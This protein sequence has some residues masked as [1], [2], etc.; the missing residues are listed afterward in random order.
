MGI[1]WGGSMKVMGSSIRFY[2]PS[3]RYTELF[4]SELVRL[5]SARLWISQIL[6]KDTA[7]IAFLQIEELYPKNSGILV[8]LNS[9]NDWG[10]IFVYAETDA[11]EA[12]FMMQISD[13][14]RS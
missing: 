14:E 8:F 12:A 3:E 2:R 9:F 10:E 6:P 13:Y 7:T 4:A 1:K 5:N 11:D